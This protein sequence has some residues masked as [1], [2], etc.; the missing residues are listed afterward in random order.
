MARTSD[1]TLAPLAVSRTWGEDSVL[2]KTSFLVIALLPVSTLP[3]R[4]LGAVAERRKREARAG[5]RAGARCSFLV[6]QHPV[7][8]KYDWAPSTQQ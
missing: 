5:A 1:L 3:V 4:V 2:N 6:C 8:R 7:P